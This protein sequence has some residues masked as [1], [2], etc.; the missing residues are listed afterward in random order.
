M[1]LIRFLGL[2]CP[3]DAQG[4]GGFGGLELLRAE[5]LRR[6]TM[7]LVLNSRLSRKLRFLG[8]AFPS[9]QALKFHGLS[10]FQFLLHW[11][12]ARGFDT[13]KSPG[14]QPQQAEAVHRQPTL[15]NPTVPIGSIG[16]HFWGLPY[17]ILNANHKKGATMEP[18]GRDTPASLISAKPT[19]Q[20]SKAYMY[21]LAGQ[22][23][24]TPRDPRCTQ[25]LKKGRKL[26]LL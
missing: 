1:G 14:L 15:E 21:S 7:G 24:P 10:A 19:Q 8:V 20:A 26:E 18:R 22:Q 17:G 3:S 4:L 6:L 2:L 5:R 13:A 23:I 16:V 25:S 11:V 12:F 9:S